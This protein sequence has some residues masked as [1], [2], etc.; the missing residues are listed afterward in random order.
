MASAAPLPTED[1]ARASEDDALGTR[2]LAAAVAEFAEQGY[3]GA[4]V[5]EIARRA[6]VTTGAIYSRYRGKAELL[7][8]AID[9]ATSDQLDEL[10]TDHRFAGRMEDILRVAGSHL[11]DRADRT[12]RESTG[13]G[14][15][16]ESFVAARHETDV[17]ALLGSRMAD[18]HDRLAA[19][20]DAAKAEGGIDERVD[21]TA[22]VMFCHAVGMGFLLLDVV[23]L[24]MPDRQDWEDLL[25]RLLRATSAEFGD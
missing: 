23:D 9:A 7:A 4:R 6:G 8:E 22:M 25:A 14:L 5:A 16:L 20:V 10:F 17:A 3:A 19:V 15:L 11:I 18:R 13:S 1:S 12:D 21:T 2:L 24:P